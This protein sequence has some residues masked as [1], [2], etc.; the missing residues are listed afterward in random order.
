MY[1]LPS[2]E[3]VSKV[4]IDGA[5]VKG[6]AEPLLIYD[7]QSK[8]CIRVINTI[9]CAIFARSHVPLIDTIP[10]KLNSCH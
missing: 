1:N 3:G 8:S 2:L 6:E 7:N 5:V 4:C 9:D 10:G